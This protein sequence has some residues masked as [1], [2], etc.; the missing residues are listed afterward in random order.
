MG[1]ESPVH[2]SPTDAAGR[3]VLLPSRMDSD[4][5]RFGGD[6]RD[7]A[8]K[9]WVQRKPET[10]KR[11]RYLKSAS[12][13]EPL[14]RSRIRKN[15]GGS[16][17]ILTNSATRCILLGALIHAPGE[18]VRFCGGQFP[19]CRSPFRPHATSPP[20]HPATPPAACILTPKTGHAA[21]PS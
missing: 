15:S 9:T 16:A 17:R 12:K 14:T 5:L 6:I 13:N 4:F 18:G 10:S 21:P 11:S 1:L 8:L 19:T 7:R 3:A 2:G 20:H